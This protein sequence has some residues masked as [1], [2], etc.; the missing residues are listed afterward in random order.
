MLRACIRS[1]FFVISLASCTAFGQHDAVQ[2]PDG[3]IIMW[4]PAQPGIE[5]EFATTLDSETHVLKL[6]TY[7]RS[8]IITPG[9]IDPYGPDTS[10]Y[11]PTTKVIFKGSLCLLYT[12]PS[13]RDS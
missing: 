7:I 13:P 9:S 5:A 4:N 2:V 10:H 8:Q 11:G 6:R 12:S 1:V 3:T